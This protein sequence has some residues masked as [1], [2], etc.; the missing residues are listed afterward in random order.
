MYHS[1]GDNDAFFT[2]SS[3]NF[4]KQMAYLHKNNF[5]VISLEEFLNN[6][7]NKKKIAAKTIVLTF[8]D[9]YED[10]YANAFSILQKYNFPATI[11]LTTGSIGRKTERKMLD[12]SQI[13]TMHQSGLIDFEPHTVSHPKLSKLVE[14]EII[15]EVVASKTIIEK[16]L[17]KTCSFFAY[18]F[19]DYN[20]QVVSI[21]KD[22][23]QAAVTVE[24]G[25]VYSTDCLFSL[26]RNSI[27]SQTGWSQFT[28][29]ALGLVEK[30]DKMKSIIKRS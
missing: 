25:A 19:G 5:K 28:G 7:K 13:K 12:W 16:E 21:A 6:F 9:G 17:N 24:P 10:N 18:P 11:F 14:E 3:Q 29:Q 20:H 8:D 4:A 27:D 1:V 2:T 26:K 23:F 30:F 15:N 22:H